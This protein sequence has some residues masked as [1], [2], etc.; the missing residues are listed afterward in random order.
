MKG[1]IGCSVHTPE[2]AAA[3][4]EEGADFLVVGT[5][6]ESV[7]HPA[8]PAAGLDLVRQTSRLGVPIIAI[9]GITPARAAEVR[10][11]GAYGIAAIRALWEAADPAAAALDLLRPWAAE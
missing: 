6:Y 4:V 10:E 8:R 7:S 2:E 5:V 3:A 11:A 9:G 1:W